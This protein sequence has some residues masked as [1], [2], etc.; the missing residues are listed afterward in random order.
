VWKSYRRYGERNQTLKQAVLR[1]KR[2]VFEES[3]AVRDLSFEVFEGETFGLIGGNGA[4]KSTT[5]KLLAGIL[6]PDSGSMQ[7]KGRVSAL[8]ELGAGF[9]PELTG[10]EN[11]FLN[12]AI[13]GIDRPSLA[14]KLDEIISFSGLSGSI[15]RPIKTYSSG[16]YARLGFSVAVNV[17]PEIL[18]LD[19]V[20]S[21]GDEEFQRRSAERIEALRGEGRTVVVVSHGMASVKKMCGRAAWLDQ[22]RVVSIGPASQV[23]D[24]YVSSVFPTAR[25][26]DLGRTRT[27]VRRLRVEVLHTKR[28]V[29]SLDR[30]RRINVRVLR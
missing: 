2:A 10:R 19:E 20:L 25:I 7:L 13:L 21:V 3:W 9:H 28:S 16:M 26:D 17:E 6:V 22:G 12:G 5:M 8:L 1:R 18:L 23:V 29:I 27:G 24:E 30:G 15:D 14:R 4:G 11:I